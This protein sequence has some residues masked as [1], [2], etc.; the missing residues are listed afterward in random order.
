VTLRAPDLAK[1]PRLRKAKPLRATLAPGEMLFIPGGFWHY[2]E[3]PDATLSVGF[4][5]WPWKRLPRLVAAELYKRLR[6]HN[7]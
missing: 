5:W 2:I 1:F 6:G 7:R 4:R 3:S